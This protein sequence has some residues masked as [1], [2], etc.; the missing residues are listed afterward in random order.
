MTETATKFPDYVTDGHHIYPWND[1]LDTLLATGKLQPC[2]A[3][4]PKAVKE[5]TPK[6]KAK[7]EDLRKK[8]LQ[9]A[10]EAVKLFKNAAPSSEELFGSPPNDK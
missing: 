1:E 4:V 8:A 7:L 6:E 3:P 5:L 9:Q 2:A 10:E